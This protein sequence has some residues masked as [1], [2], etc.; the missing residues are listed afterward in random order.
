VG[1]SKEAGVARPAPE[2]S[3]FQKFLLYW[4][5]VLLYLTVIFVL[6]AQPNLKP[7]IQWQQS[8]KIY[9]LAE[10]IGLGVL[11][12]RA[13]RGTFPA[14]RLMMATVLAVV[15]G[16]CVAAGDEYFQSFIPG[17]DSSVFDFMADAAG[18]IIAQLAT[19]LLSRD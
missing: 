10:Y 17:R 1:Q 4:L 19:L 16:W 13:M 6:S 14:R 5:P 8:D 15:L 9:H 3:L 12:S 11:L 2:K 18:I 7:P